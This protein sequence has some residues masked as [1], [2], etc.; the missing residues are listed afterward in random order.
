MAL[1]ALTDRI[2]LISEAAVIE[3]FPAVASAPDGWVFAWSQAQGERQFIYLL[4]TDVRGYPIERILLWQGD[5]Y[6]K[7][8]PAILSEG[9]ALYIAS[10]YGIRAELDY[11]AATPLQLTRLTCEETDVDICAQDAPQAATDGGVP[12][13]STCASGVPTVGW[14]WTGSRCEETTGCF[15]HCD[16]PDCPRFALSEA[17][18]LWDH[19]GCRGASL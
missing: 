3:T 14:R 8:R 7:H 17:D 6:D 9:D 12:D 19:R 2:L 5:D 18:C 10:P 16:A 13:E 4:H 1:N 15:R 11:Y